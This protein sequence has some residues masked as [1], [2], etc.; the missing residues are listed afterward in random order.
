MKL[1]A[2]LIEVDEPLELEVE[3]SETIKSVKEMIIKAVY[4]ELLG[5]L[6]SIKDE[7]VRSVDGP[8]G[9]QVLIDS[10]KLVFAGKVLENGLSLEGYNIQKET[11]LHVILR[12]Q[13][14]NVNNLYIS[15]SSA[16]DTTFF[17]G[18]PNEVVEEIAKNIESPC[19][20]DLAI[21]ISRGWVA[22]P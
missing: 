14:E 22:T 21:N 18:L 15:L 20:E 6:N 19:Y 10:V 11:T 3:K 5:K 16:R 2:K 13:P 12:M 8:T 17:K 9:T 7:V 1:Y 4:P